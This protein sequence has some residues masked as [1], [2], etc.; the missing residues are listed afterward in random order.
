MLH[1]DNN[2]AS[3]LIGDATCAVSYQTHPGEGGGASQQ[4]I[5]LLSA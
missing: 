2:S 4:R 1:N 3:A 5:L